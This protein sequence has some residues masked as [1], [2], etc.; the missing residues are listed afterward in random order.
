MHKSGKV[1]KTMTDWTTQK[2]W[3]SPGARRE[4]HPRP[5]GLKKILQCLLPGSTLPAR[6]FRLLTQF[7]L[8][9]DFKPSTCSTWFEAPGPPHPGDLEPTFK[10]TIFKSSSSSMGRLPKKPHKALIFGTENRF[11]FHT[12][13]TPGTCCFSTAS[14]DHNGHMP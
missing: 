5:R 3:R 4:D 9:V 8:R 7:S 1:Y 6:Y 14:L 13:F 2:G 12:S 10:S 11:G